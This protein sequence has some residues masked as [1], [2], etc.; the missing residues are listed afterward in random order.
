MEQKKTLKKY[1]FVSISLL[2]LMNWG[3]K[4][5]STVGGVPIVAVNLTLYINNPS[6]TSLSAVGGWMYIDGGVKGIVIYR[7]SI[8]DF[9]AYDR[10]CTYNPTSTC[11]TIVVE[12]TNIIAVDSCCGSKFSILD[13]SV[14]NGPAAL[15]LKQY[16]TFYDG[17][18]LRIY[19]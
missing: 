6:Y 16:N 1:L 10:N 17:N 8:S 5:E 12:N 4:K 18:I 19:N 7:E 11:A 14:I 3:C 13:G 15:S 9:K 2:V